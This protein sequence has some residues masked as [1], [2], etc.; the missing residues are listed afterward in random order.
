MFAE[1]NDWLYGS[2]CE[3]SPWTLGVYYGMALY[4]ELSLE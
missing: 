2:G 4:L 3:E 1:N